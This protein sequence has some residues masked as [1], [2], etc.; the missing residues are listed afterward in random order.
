MARKVITALLCRMKRNMHTVHACLIIPAKIVSQALWLSYDWS[1]ALEANLVPDSIW[2]YDPNSEGNFILEMK[3]SKDRLIS[4]MEI[5]LSVR[6]NLY[7]ESALW[8]LWVNYSHESTENRH[9]NHKY[10]YIYIYMYI[11]LKQLYKLWIQTT[12]NVLISSGGWEFDHSHGAGTSSPSHWQQVE[13][14]APKPVGWMMCFLLMT[15]VPVQKLCVNIY[16]YICVHIPY[17][18]S[19]IGCIYNGS[20]IQ[21]WRSCT[22]SCSTGEC[23]VPGLNT[24]LFSLVYQLCLALW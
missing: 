20:V 21:Y 23:A 6:Q 4:T 1:D 22:P 15:L 2:R 9:Y 7:V 5:L 13:E 14:Q 8:I 18:S 24:M 3:R 19:V 10:I 16:L 11:Y 17:T 12:P